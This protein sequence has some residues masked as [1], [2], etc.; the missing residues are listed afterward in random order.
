M[1]STGQK[2]NHGVKIKSALSS[3][4]FF[5]PSG[6]QNEQAKDGERAKILPGEIKKTLFTISC[7][8]DKMIFFPP[9]SHFL[10]S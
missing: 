2:I 5:D 8:N 3:G 7:P 6:R 4:P 9:S 1:R 10:F